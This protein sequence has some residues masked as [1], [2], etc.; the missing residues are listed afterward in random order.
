MP[1]AARTVVSSTD[2]VPWMPP[3]RPASCSTSSTRTTSASRSDSVEATYSCRVRNETR[4]SMRRSRSPAPN[5]RTPASSPPSP[6]R[7]EW[8]A[9]TRPAA[10]GIESSA[11][12]TSLT[13]YTLIRRARPVPGSLISSPSAATACATAGPSAG[14][15]QRTAWARS[16]RSAPVPGG[17]EVTYGRSPCGT[18]SHGEIAVRRTTRSYGTSSRLPTV[19]TAESCPPSPRNSTSVATRTVGTR[20]GRRQMPSAAPSANGAASTTRSTWPSSIAPASSSPTRSTARPSAWVGVHR[21]NASAR[22]RP[23]AAWSVGRARAIASAP[24]RWRGEPVRV[25]AAARGGRPGSGQPLRVRR[26]GAAGRRRYPGQHVGHDRGRVGLA[27]PHLRLERDPVGQRRDGHL[28]DVLRDHVVAAGQRRPGPGEQ[29]QR[30]RPARGR[31]DQYLVVLPGRRGQLHDVVPDGVLHH[32]VLQRVLH[33]EQGGRVHDR[34]EAGLLLAAGDPPAQY[35]PFLVP[36]GIAERDPQQEPG[37]VPLV[38]RV[39]ALVLA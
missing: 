7:R 39:R 19:S 26:Q 10:R 32:D 36:V 38:Q 2:R 17:T 14:R 28:L 25:D 30:Q 12:N 20:A 6:G 22:C 37:Q 1:A 21:R 16:G 5:I 27:Q 35:R 23:R 18:T 13:G 24:R 31:P 29:Q 15:P 34:F 11:S 4:Q 8:C 3:D 33:G 9:P